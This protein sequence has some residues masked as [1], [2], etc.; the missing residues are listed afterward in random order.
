MKIIV[1]KKNKERHLLRY[2][3]VMEAPGFHGNFGPSSDMMFRVANP[4]FHQASYFII[5]IIF[6]FG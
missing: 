2:L 6:A 1:I 3:S 5:I 4:L